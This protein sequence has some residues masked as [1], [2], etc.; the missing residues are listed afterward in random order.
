MLSDWRR[1]SGKGL[2][3]VA[4]WGASFVATRIALESFHPFGLVAIRLWMGAALL[5]LLARRASPKRRLSSADYPAGL[6]LG[7]VLAAHLLIQAYGLLYTSA[8]NTGWIIGFMPVTI[9]LGAY[10]LGQQRLQPRGWAG[11]ALGTVGVLLVTAVTPPNFR[12]ARWGDLL[13]IGSCLTWTVYTLAA[14]GPLARLGPLR[15][16][17]ASMAVA[18]AIATVATMGSGLTRGPL[19]VSAVG[20]TVFL[21]VACSGVAYYLWLAAMD[22]HGPA[23]VSAL[24]YFEPFVTLATAVLLKDEP[25][26]LNALAGGLCVLAGVWLV[27]RGSTKRR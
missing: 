9:A 20:A 18:A 2:S 6:F 11:V 24:L 21:G 14:A 27:A 13:Q 5:F 22:E 15:V 25:I 12:H 7:A 16:T 17:A 4:V 1:I 19:F 26:T 8:I 3:A 23:R 10:L